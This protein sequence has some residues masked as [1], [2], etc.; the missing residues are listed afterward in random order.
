MRRVVMAVAV[1]L[2]GGLVACAAGM[3]AP[4]EPE[5]EERRCTSDSDCVFRPDDPCECDPCGTAWRR[6]VSQQAAA[7][8]LGEQAAMRCEPPECETCET[9]WRGTEPVCVSGQCTVRHTR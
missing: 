2:I 3:Q 8:I 5:S 1:A 7:D 6:A 9:D 4:S